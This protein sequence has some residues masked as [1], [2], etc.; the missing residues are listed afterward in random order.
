MR[1]IA[2]LAGCIVLLSGTLGAAEAPR[3]VGWIDAETTLVYA[4]LSR[5]ASLIDVASG[6][7]VRTLLR[8]VPAYGRAL[9]APPFRQAHEVVEHLS[10]VLETT[11]EDGLRKLLA[12]AVLAVEGENGP[13]RV[14]L[15]V[16][17]EDPEFLKRAHEKLVELARQDA[18]SHGRPDP[19]QETD[20]RDVHAYSVAPTEAHAILDGCLVVTNGGD[21]LKTLI[22]RVKDH[23]G[24]E[25]PLIDD[26]TWTARRAAVDP[27]AA[28]WTLARLDRLRAIDPKR[29][30]P[31]K[32][33]PGAT[34]LLGPWIDAARKADWVTLSFTWNGERLAA[35]ATLPKP[36]EAAR[37]SEAYLPEP[38][39]GATRPI[40]V[41]RLIASLSL[42]RDLAAIWEA[43]GEIFPPESQAGFAQLD[44]T[45]GTFFGGRDFG[46]GVLGSLGTNWRLV[47]ARQEPESLDPTPENLLPA[48]AVVLDVKEE[49]PDFGDRLEAA[50]QS[51]VGLV[52]L[53]S[54]Q[55]KAP[56]LR[57]GSETFE[58]VNI[59][60]SRFQVRREPNS[61]E[62]VH[63]RHN[64]TPSA[65]RFDGHFVL[66]SSAALARDL[67]QTL[68][69]PPAAA[70]DAAV[71]AVAD[72]P[73][74]ARLVEQNREYLVNQN[75]LEKGNDRARAEGEVD[76]LRQLLEYLG[77]ATYTADTQDGTLRVRLNH[78]LGR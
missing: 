47:V 30:A 3:P 68:R 17:P 34:F 1:R 31:E 4:E 14:Y 29:F 45:A 15:I 20:H 10:R 6:D 18:A 27:E 16:T 54:A 70:T 76:L 26:A 69:Q 32:V 52:N 28:A 24:A 42:W 41:P 9:D 64:F 19:V 56:P 51:F 78:D 12:G 46:T 71:L 66:S 33:E 38:G 75:V 77:Q 63:L 73:E 21:S 53:G 35:E 57:L 50:F 72:G 55:T 67:I 40:R 25:H 5:P 43:R 36:V 44:S 37:L 59:A 39:Q 7:R 22:D 11:P 2:G 62:P 8:A 49:D 65:A 48:F 13:Q 23:G 74:L 60:T 58:G 61:D